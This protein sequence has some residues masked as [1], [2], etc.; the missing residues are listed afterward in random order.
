MIQGEFIAIV[1]AFVSGSSIDALNKCA[2]TLLMLFK[3]S[4]FPLFVSTPLIV[5]RS[6]TCRKTFAAD[7]LTQRN[8]IGL[9]PKA[10][11][12]K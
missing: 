12:F 5:Y 4:S 7:R 3:L 6:P 1:N 2:M 8:T 11:L 10:G 9:Y